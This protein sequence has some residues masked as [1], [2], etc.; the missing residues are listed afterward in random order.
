MRIFPRDAFARHGAGNQTV[1]TTVGGEEI[2]AGLVEIE[3][4]RTSKGL[5]D[6]LLTAGWSL[7]DAVWIGKIRA[8]AIGADDPEALRP[9]LGHH[10]LEMADATA[11]LGDIFGVAFEKG[12]N[13][14]AILVTH[15][16][17][18]PVAVEHDLEESR[19]VALLFE[20]ARR[21]LYWF[22]TPSH[23]NHP[24]RCCCKLE[25][26]LAAIM[27]TN[28]LFE[29]KGPLEFRSTALLAAELAAESLELL[30]ARLLV[31][32]RTVAIG[33]V[34]EVAAEILDLALHQTVEE[35]V[36]DARHRRRRQHGILEQ[37]GERRGQLAAFVGIGPLQRSDADA[38]PEIPT[39]AKKPF[40]LGLAHIVG[41]RLPRRPTRLDHLIADLV[42]C[43]TR[44]V[45]RIEANDPGKVP[46]F[47]LE[48]ILQIIEESL[49]V[50]G[51]QDLAVA[52][53]G[54]DES[55]NGAPMIGI[56]G[57]HD[58]IQRD[59][60]RADVNCWIAAMRNASAT[61]WICESLK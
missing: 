48:L 2:I 17:T 35:P 39:D 43:E 37:T 18:R 1:R 57:G 20:T 27:R 38:D 6:L 59:D 23:S 55:G 28:W 16:L 11:D 31:A 14:E 50:G 22:R 15:S 9:M 46:R 7:G 5:G 29:S 44:P 4:H 52:E 40:L 53:H 60:R 56:V 10:D 33:P 54:G 3:A 24:C 12:G 51:D 30:P 41:R 26:R 32:N 25:L 34:L 13:V 47:R 36:V 58:V 19:G 49:V 21:Q 8:A 42:I 61:E 45:G